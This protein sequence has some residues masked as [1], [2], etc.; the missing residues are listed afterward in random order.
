[1]PWPTDDLEDTDLQ[2]AYSRPSRAR[3]VIVRMVEIVR[4]ILALRYS[5]A[6]KT[7]TATPNPIDTGGIAG[8]DANGRLGLYQNRF[9]GVNGARSAEVAMLD[10]AAK[11]TLM[12]DYIGIVGPE[13][14]TGKPTA[15]APPINADGRL[16]VGSWEGNPVQLDKGGNLAAP[17]F[18]DLIGNLKINIDNPSNLSSIKSPAITGFTAKRVGPSSIHLK[19][20][21]R[22]MDITRVTRLPRPKQPRRGGGEGGGQ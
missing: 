17:H 10:G 20:T 2:S 12:R 3:A 15:T 22:S 18:L 1:M 8:L 14:T 13:E 11:P 7:A 4:A 21:Y 6:S 9:V 5:G 19:P 16:W